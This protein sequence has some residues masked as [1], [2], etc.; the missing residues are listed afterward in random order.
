M[1]FIVAIFVV[2]FCGCICR[3]LFSK[4]RL[5]RQYRRLKRSCRKCFGRDTDFDSDDDSVD[6]QAEADERQRLLSRRASFYTYNRQLPPTPRS[7]RVQFGPDADK[8]QFGF[9][10]S[11]T[12][13]TTATTTDDHALAHGK[14][15]S[16]RPDEAKRVLS[17]PTKPVQEA[18]RSASSE[19]GYMYD[20]GASSMISVESNEPV[21][22]EPSNM[23]SMRGAVGNNSKGWS[24]WEK[25]R[26]ELLKKYDKQT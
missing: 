22:R 14:R 15:P 26:K 16:A 4:R 11:P 24:D 9:I 10:R 18:S 1:S 20:Q 8:P 2:L 17:T 13:R 23:D 25:K 7:P 12:E 6:E 5:K 3:C 19:E 21:T